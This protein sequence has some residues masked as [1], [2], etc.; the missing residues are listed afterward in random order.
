MGEEGAERDLAMICL[1]QENDLAFPRSLAGKMDF[2]VRLGTSQP[3]TKMNTCPQPDHQGHETLGFLTEAVMPGTGD[4][5]GKRKRQ[6]AEVNRLHDVFTYVKVN[7]QK[8]K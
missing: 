7:T 8:K 2:L 1:T 6:P 5:K 4:G 3:L